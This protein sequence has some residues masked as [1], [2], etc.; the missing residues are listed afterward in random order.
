MGRE[1]T[2]WTTQDE[3]KFIERLGKKTK[4]GLTRFE[5]LKNYEVALNNR[6]DFGSMNEELVRT[7]LSNEIIKEMRN[8]K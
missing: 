7:F 3:F 2:T 8:S 1:R 5:I 6:S 4:S